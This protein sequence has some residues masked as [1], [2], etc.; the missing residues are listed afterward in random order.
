M[1]ALSNLWFATF[2]STSVLQISRRNDNRASASSSCQKRKLI[3]GT[4]VVL[5]LL[6]LWSVG[7]GY[8]RQGMRFITE[9][10]ELSAT[11]TKAMEKLQGLSGRGWK[12][13]R[14][15]RA[16]RAGHEDSTKHRTRDWV[17]LQGYTRAPDGVNVLF[18]AYKAVGHGYQSLTE[19]TEL[20]GTG[21]T[22]EN[23]WVCNKQYSTE[24]SLGYFGHRPPRM[25]GSRIDNPGTGLS[26]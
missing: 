12:A 22:R 14:T 9:L 5:I 11:G 21:K 4:R 1:C 23:T 10:T 8:L 2:S 26:F 25:R 16:C 6:R 18:T 17:F 13:Y 3:A 19:V 20:T 7:Y 24:H 15:H